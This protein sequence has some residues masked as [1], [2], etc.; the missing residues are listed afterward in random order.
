[1]E[2]PPLQRTELGEEDLGSAIGG[3]PEGTAPI[4]CNDNSGFIY[5][6]EAI[7]CDARAEEWNCTFSL[8]RHHLAQ[9]AGKVTAEHLVDPRRAQ[10]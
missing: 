8:L 7:H 1:V 10:P 2:G 4:A 5:C 3:A 6:T 9:I